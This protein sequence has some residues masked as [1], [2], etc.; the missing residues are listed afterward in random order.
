VSQGVYLCT[1]NHDWTDPAFGLV[2]KPITIDTC[3]WVGAR[4][5]VCPG[6]TVGEGAVV[7][8]GGVVAR[9]VPPYEVHA[10]NPA[11]VVRVRR[12]LS[13]LKTD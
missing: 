1:G 11:V 10:G 13:P 9:N 2:L 8:V 6:V 5:T 3:A 7:A 4:A 12:I